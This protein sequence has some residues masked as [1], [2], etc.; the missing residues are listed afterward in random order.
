MKDQAL[1]FHMKYLDV[2]KR[3]DK[4]K[5]IPIDPF[6]WDFTMNHLGSTLIPLGGK[7]ATTQ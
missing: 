6:Q 2:D 7:L 4:A 5:K 3:S 1:D